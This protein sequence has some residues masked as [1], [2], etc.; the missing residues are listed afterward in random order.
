[1]TAEDG[2]VRGPPGQVTVG[3]GLVGELQIISQSCA[4]VYGLVFVYSIS[5]STTILVKNRNLKGG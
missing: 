5:Q 3:E 2:L 4:L 1:M